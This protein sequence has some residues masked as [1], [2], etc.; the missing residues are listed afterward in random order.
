[1]ALRA[2]HRKLQRYHR[3]HETGTGME[4]WTCKDGAKSFG[5][6]VR[7]RRSQITVKSGVL[8]HGHDRLRGSGTMAA[9][10]GRFQSCAICGY[11]RCIADTRKRYNSVLSACDKG[12]R[13][14]EALET[15]KDVQQ[16]NLGNIVSYST[17]MSACAKGAQWHWAI[18]LLKSLENANLQPNQVTYA[19]AISACEKGEGPLRDVSFRDVRGRWA[20]ALGILERMPPEHRDLAAISACEKASQWQVALEMF[21]K[22][23]EQDMV[24]HN[25]VASACAKAQQWLE[26]TSLLQRAIEN[27]LQPNV[28]SYGTVISSFEESSLYSQLA[29]AS[30][31][32]LVG[33]YAGK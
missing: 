25:A 30:S 12:H 6:T 2:E 20:E 27:Q 33:R 31:Y 4:T 8:R 23:P 26:A 5:P 18:F 13:W 14:Q 1:M 15:L 10:V 16:L 17:A 19:A 9:S 24:A 21:V 29:V 28:I 22:L 32:P 3:D 11:S 7:H